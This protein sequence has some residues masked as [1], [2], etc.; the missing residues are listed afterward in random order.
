[1]DKGVLKEILSLID[2]DDLEEEKEDSEESDESEKVCPHCGEKLG[3]EMDSTEEMMKRKLTYP[4]A[5]TFKP[6]NADKNDAKI[7]ALVKLV[8]KLSDS[9]E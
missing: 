4:E 1:M 7:E 3:E 5:V 9:K 2:F 6:E 8:T